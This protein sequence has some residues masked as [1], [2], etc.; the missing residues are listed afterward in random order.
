M[1]KIKIMSF[2]AAAVLVSAASFTSCANDED[3]AGAPIAA[4]DNAI[5]YRLG[6]GT[7][8][9]GTTPGNYLDQVN[10]FKVWGYFAVGATGTGVTEGSQYVGSADNG[11][12]INGDGTGAWTN[13]DPSQIS[14]WPAATAPLNFQAVTPAAD[15]SF[16][17]ENNVSNKL[18]HVVA[19]V[20]VPTDNALQR[21][22]M[23][24]TAPSITGAAS[25]WKVPLQF[26]HGLSQIVFNGKVNSNE[27]SANVK[28]ITVCNIQQKGKVGFLSSA[29]A[30]GAVNLASEITG[31]NLAKFDLGMA[32]AVNGTDIAYSADPSAKEELTSTDGDGQHTGALL[33][34]PQNTTKWTPV[35]GTP[36]TNS[37]D[38][39]IVVECKIKNGSVYLVGDDSTYGKIYIPF[40]AAWEMGKK[41]TYTLNIGTGEGAYDDNGNPLIH[42]ISYS[43]A[44]DDW[45]PVNGGNILP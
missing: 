19:N 4:S 7:R 14:Y 18:A 30:S 44:V 25:S 21:D 2:A 8:A 29:D 17:I 32:D 15:A 11:V 34:L 9:L 39:Y 26:K 12:I 28:Q 6:M 16:T 22:I 40:A 10:D 41:Y 24:A 5:T 20:T 1:K 45:T 43:V 33:M 35:A 42:V 37:D 27:I 38:S 23:F 13:A 3:G 31:N 36:V